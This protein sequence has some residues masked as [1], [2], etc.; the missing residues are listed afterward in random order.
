MNFNRHSNFEGLHAFMSASKYHWVNYSDEKMLTVWKNMQAAERGTRLHALAKEH[1]ELGIKMPRTK[2]TLD[3]FVNDAIGFR[4]EPEVVLV[5]SE[6]CFG[7]ADAIGFRDDFL[8]IHD[9]KTGETVASMMQ[10]RI[11]MA[12][13][14]LEYRKEP[15]RIESELRIYQNDEVFIETP[16]PM[17]IRKIMDTIVR[18]DNLIKISKEKG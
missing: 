9:L 8:R 16:D 11:Y 15:D 17:E 5:Y 12:L 6:N 3:A 2:K 18:F 14:C 10:P 1:I 7:T 13:F 4:M